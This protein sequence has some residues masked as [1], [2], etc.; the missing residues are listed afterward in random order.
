MHVLRELKPTTILRYF[1]I[2][3]LRCEN[4]NGIVSD[5]STRRYL[6]LF[7]VIRRILHLIMTFVNNLQF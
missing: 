3:Q 4:R 7:N 2:L 5:K 1:L 6:P